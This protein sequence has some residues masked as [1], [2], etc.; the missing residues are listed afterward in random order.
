VS[1]RNTLG[2]SS[3]PCYR[4]VPVAS[5]AVHDRG[6]LAGVRLVGARDFDR[7][8]SFRDDIT[9]RLGHSV[10][11]ACVVSFHG[12]FRPDQVDHPLGKPPPDGSGT[13]ALVV[14]TIPQNQLVGTFVLTREPLP[15]RH[16]V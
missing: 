2:T 16:E 6:A 10:R 4:A 12:Q 15:I 7:H 14:V 11:S 3:S 5:E 9:T 1:P 13:V 8:P